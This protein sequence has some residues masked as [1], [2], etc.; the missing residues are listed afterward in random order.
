M[1]T[2]TLLLSITLGTLA[3]QA[4]STPQIPCTQIHAPVHHLRVLCDACGC[5]AN[6]GSMGFGTGLNNNFVGMRY[7]NQRYRSQTDLYNKNLWNDEDFNTLQLW[8]QIPLGQSIV[9]NAVLPYHFHSRT[10]S[11]NTKQHLN[12]LGDAILLA[13]YQVVKQTPDSIVTIVPQHILQ[14]G[15]GIKAPTGEF[16]R[17]NLEGSVNPSFQLG[18][19][20]W[21]VLVGANYGLTHRNWGL[22]L[23]ASYIFKSENNK[24]YRFGNQLN[25]AL[26][27][28]KT[29]YLGTNFALTPQLGIGGEHFDTDTEFGFRKSDTGGNALFGK[30]GVEARYVQYAL[31]IS[32]MQ[33]LAQDLNNGRVEI[34]NRLSLYVNFNL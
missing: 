8:S 25:Y 30:V 22:F 6:G 15:G 16:S 13:Y 23:T 14:L 28:Y 17:E 7:I 2:Y 27:T 20:S 32:A 34:K 26:N 4:K 21:D 1:K 18:T 10:I 9:I 24:A 12:G 11:G 31:G 5:S 29:Y 3:L 19:G 33:P